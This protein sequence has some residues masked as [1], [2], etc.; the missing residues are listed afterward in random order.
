MKRRYFQ[1][2]VALLLVRSFNTPAAV[3][4][5]NLNNPTPTPPYTNWV[6]AAT[7][8]Q[9]A[10]D[11]ANSG[12]TILITDGVYTTGGRTHA[13]TGMSTNRVVVDKAV[14]VQSIN[15]PAAT[16]IQGN[17][18]VGPT[19]VR[20][21]YLTNNAA[22]IGFTLTNGATRADGDVGRDQIGGGAWCESTNAVIS[23]CYLTSNAAATGGGGSYRGTLYNCVIS[24]NSGAVLSNYG[25]GGGANAAILNNCL[26]VGNSAGYSGGGA[27]TSTLN[28]CTIVSNSV[29]PHGKGVYNCILNNCISY[30]NN[31][32]DNYSGGTLNYCCTTPLP[33]SGMGNIVSPP[34]FVNQAG[35]NFRLQTNSPCI[36]TGN[37]A[38]VNSATD[39]DG[40]PRIFGSTVDMGAYELQLTTFLG[41]AVQADATNTAVG[42]SLYF[43]GSTLGGAATATHWDFGDGTSADNRLNVS[44]SWAAAGDYPVVFT[45]Y[46]NSN[47]GGISATV[48]VH[49]ITQPV[50][51]V[52]LTSTNPVAPYLSWDTAATN[53]QDAVDTA[54]PGSQIL[55]TN[56]VYQTGGRIHASTGMSINRVVVDKAVM[57]QS[58]NGPAVT[59]IQGNAGVGPTGI[60]CIY[61]TNDAVL[62]GFTLTQGATRKDGNAGREQIGGGAW[63]ESTSAVICNCFLIGNAAVSGGGGTY[64]GTLYNC[65]IS[66]NSS[67]VLP[68]YGSG[69]G[70]NAAVLNNSLVVGNTATYSGGGA[71]TCTLNNCTIV[72]NSTA[73]SG[74]GVYNCTLNNCISYYNNGGDNYSGGTLNYCCTMPLPGSGVDNITNAPIYVNLANGDF[75]LQAN[76]PCVNMGNNAYVNGTTDLD[77]NSRIFGGTVDIGAYELQ[78]FVPFSV[79]VQ[80]DMTN[81]LIGYS[82]HLSS[83]T[84]GGAATMCHWD[85]GDGTSADNQL[86]VSHSWAAAGDYPVVFT[87]YND[88]NPGGVSATVMVHIVTQFI[89]YVAL[90]STNPV[91]P[92]LSWDTA[93]TNIQDAVDAVIPWGTVLVSNGV[94]QTGGRIHASTDMSTNRVVVNKAVTVQSVNG[95]AVTAIQ[96]NPGVGPTGVRCIYLTNNAALV[97]FTLTQGATRADGNLGRD[98]IGGGAW[99]ESTSVLISNCFL[100][101]NTAAQG[102]GGSY[103]GTLY[104]CVISG[105]SGSVSSPSGSG[106]GAN[107]AVL[108]NCLV[109]CNSVGY[110]G[111]GAD[112]CTLNNCT[113]VSNSVSHYGGGVYNCTLNN[114]ISYYNSGNNNYS[115]GT[116]NYCCTMP[117][118]NGGT[119]NVTNAPAFV[120]LANGDFHLQTNSPCV[121]A[122]NNAYVNG[123]TDLDGNPR[124]FSG[125]VD[126]GAYE[127]QTF[128]PFGVTV[129]ADLTNAM[130]NFPVHFTGF[131]TGGSATTSHWDFGDGSTA[132]NQLSI[133]H[134]WAAAGDYPVVFT[135]YNVSNPGGVSA[136]VM[137]HV[138][139]QVINYV[140][141]QSTNPVAPYLS[142][143]TA[144]TNIQDAVDTVVPGGT[145]LVSN[146]V[147]Q[148]GGRTHPSTDVSTNRVVVD[149]AVTVQSINGPVVTVIQ[150]NPGIGPTGVRCIYL[151]NGAVLIGFTLT[152]GAT[153][154]NGTAG[155]DQIGGGAWCESTSAVISNCFLIGNAARSGAGGTYRGTLYNCVISGNKGSVPLDYGSGGGANAA[156]LN[157]CLVVSNTAAASGGGADTC[158]LNNCTIVS[159]LVVNGSGGGVYNCVLNNCISYYNNGI[160]YYYNGDDNYSGGTLNY[161]C[162]APLPSSG[163][164]NIPNAPIFVNLA[165]GDFHLQTNSSC[166]NAGNNTYVA[167]TIDL[168]G[169]PRIFS[170]TVDMGAYE[171]QVFVP[172]GVTVQADATNAIIGHSLHFI[173][174]T[175]GGAATTSHWDFGDG[176]TA[177]NQLSVS[178]SWAAA[179]DYPVLFAAYNDSNPG[180]MSATVM[181]HIVAPS[182]H[183][184]VALGCTN[185]VLPYSTWDT[186]ASNIQDAVDAVI[187]GGIVSVSNGVYQTGGRTHVSTGTSTNR[188][189]LDKAVTVQS[190]NGPVVTIIQGNP[191]IGTNGIRCIYLTNGA[192]LIGFTLTQGATR[193]VSD[194]GPS[195]G[196]GAWCESTNAAI[197]NCYLASNAASMYGGGSYQGTLYNCVI[198]GNSA[199]YSGGGACYAVLN[200]CLVSSNTT[201]SAGGGA[202]ICT[203]INCTIV[204]N[205]AAGNGKGVYY[206]GLNN[207]ISY[208]NGNNNYYSG[209]LNYCCTTPLPGGTGNITNAPIFVD[210]ANGD[211]HLQTNSPCINAGNNAYVTTTNDLDGNPRIVGGTV[212]IGAYEFQTPTSVISY[213]WLQQYGLTNDGT[214]DYVDTDSD[215]MNNWQ[216]W[217]TGT[218]PTNALS[219][220][221]MASATRTNNPP[222][223]VVTWQSVNTR[224][225]YLQRSTDLTAQPA[226]STVQSNIIGQAGTTSYTDTTATNGGP[227][228]YR[229][230]VQ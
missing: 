144:A 172:F 183:G 173:G 17:P 86:S 67:S 171:L 179:G 82:L 200:N 123:A 77:G 9:D 43:I 113:I 208:Y 49:V 222:G 145:V 18:S 223:M 69:G 93:A 152:Q 11:A 64:R 72:S 140:T 187:P 55:V 107:A 216:E 97:G 185:P 207:C 214:A 143:D 199:G 159:N 89:S 5:V 52:N 32:G 219:V 8:I 41:V 196:G 132:D 161:C 23:N 170:D 1:W 130:I 114:C 40:N 50:L 121:N 34:S 119:G 221:K 181:V 58:V 131:T 29:A 102:G 100:I 98:Q 19:G 104:N 15:G 61:L 206:C 83:S 90:Q 33:S 6:A 195:S 189:V 129:Q 126:I 68:N 122:G 190:V 201:P 135:A 101:G 28:N 163:T 95:P 88:S 225:Y 128:V 59:V 110:S 212:D 91:A 53:I 109:V 51:Y 118:P 192:A 78:I 31:D 106:G 229:V 210:L 160:S 178:H 142:W 81:A 194:L 205:S 136:T 36:N 124:I 226:F 133:S 108:N 157:N 175:M 149:K 224:T 99:C 79:A 84:T 75:H 148:I 85:F 117:L 14:T 217:K 184:Y 211:F 25:S 150:G 127:L 209:T 37:N 56:G 165:N 230:G 151:T 3:L 204:S 4:Y 227:Y 134:G 138:V 158:T 186:A 218:N 198:S 39:L 24:G 220:L 96:G 154:T 188:V 30:Y 7:N 203:L 54:S 16:I 115:G 202:S 66:G 38:Y 10:V 80:A 137:V 141:L 35:G 180:G 169:N 46:N 73:G 116:L 213:A 112:T 168:D 167:S 228:F 139:T 87:A 62:I 166:V 27:D 177:D 125:I 215:G 42:F 191:G 146:G 21:I 12:D 164:G 105:N 45:A 63:C 13:S 176:T 71:D 162:T 65:I 48:M 22:L 147:Y 44:H 76:S 120:N 20:C 57:V 26:V 2:A 197:S 103:R 111:G 174:S 70:A 193:G 155:Q 182:L 156:V 94:Y 74:N 92:Y 60:R 153:R 47:P